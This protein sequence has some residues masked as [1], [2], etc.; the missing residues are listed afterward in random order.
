M[1]YTNHYLGYFF[2][3]NENKKIYFFNYFLSSFSNK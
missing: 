1:V 2:I 3:N